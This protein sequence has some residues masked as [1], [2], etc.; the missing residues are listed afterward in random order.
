MIPF[1]FLLAGTLIIFGLMSGHSIPSVQAQCGTTST[2]KTCHETLAQKPVNQSGAWHIDHASYDLCATCH[3]GSS[4]DEEELAAHAGITINLVDM[5]PSCYNCHPDEYSVYYQK[6]ADQLGLQAAPSISASSYL[7]N[8]G[9]V[10]C[11]SPASVVPAIP[12]A[13]V[14]NSGNFL[15]IGVITLGVVIGG[16][17]IAFNEHRLKKNRKGGGKQ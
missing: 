7:Q 3:S 17:L 14:S 8:L 15:L 10:L 11:V 4:T 12:S 13:T 2:C 5:A 6:Y 9:N 1:L 16:L